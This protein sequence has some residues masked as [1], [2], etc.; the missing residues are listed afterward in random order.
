MKIVISGTTG[1]GKS[2][3]VN[4][5]KNYYQ[6]KGKKV[7]IMGEILIESPYFD[8]YFN[9]F[10]NWSFLAQID[11]LFERFHQFIEVEQKY[12]NDKNIIIIYDRHF[13]E[14]KIFS[15][16]RLIKKTRSDKLGKAY[17]QIY[18]SMLDKINLF[19]KPDFFIVLRA[20]FDV[21]MKRMEKRNREQEKKFDREYWQD[22]Y[23]RYYAKK[24]NKDIFRKYSKKYLELD[25]DYLA[26]NEVTKKII[27]YI[28]KRI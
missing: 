22:L 23:Y 17:K 13:I 6:R 12:K 7:I 8:L 5:L 26:I 10:I 11:F 21:I 16:L 2:T 4:N 18:N 28:N 14:D 9:D 24:A 20:S 3:T 25:T 15:E 27:K 19:E 1:V